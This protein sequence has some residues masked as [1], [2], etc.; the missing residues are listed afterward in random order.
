MTVDLNGLQIPKN[1]IFRRT[2]GSAILLHQ[3]K[4][5]SI[6]CFGEGDIRGD[7]A[8]PVPADPPIFQIFALS[9]IF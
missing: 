5:I 7:R 1:E 9:S 2:Q 3:L 8:C 6:K 4:K